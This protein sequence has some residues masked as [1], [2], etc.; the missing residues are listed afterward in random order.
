MKNTGENKGNVLAIILIVVLFVGL[1]ALVVDGWNRN[2][3]VECITW[4]NQAKEYSGF[5]LTEWQY[6]QCK[7]HNIYIGALVVE[8]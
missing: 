3:I 7:A 4:Q 5:F 2:E 6:Q 1:G 8:K